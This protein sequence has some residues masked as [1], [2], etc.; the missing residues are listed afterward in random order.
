MNKAILLL[1]ILPILSFSHRNKI[2]I[3]EGFYC[4]HDYLIYKD[5]L[6]IEDYEIRS[7]MILLYI[8]GDTLANWGDVTFSAGG[9]KTITAKDSLMTEDSRIRIFQVDNG[10]VGLTIDGIKK[11]FYYDKIPKDC[12][13]DISEIIFNPNDDRLCFSKII[14]SRIRNTIFSGSYLFKGTQPVLFEGDG[15]VKGLSYFKNYKLHFRGGTDFPYPGHNL[16]ETDNG[17]WAYKIDGDKY[18]FTRYND[19]RNNDDEMY[20]LSKMKFELKRER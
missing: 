8:H 13:Q 10:K 4:L 7:D 6:T 1:I 3:E 14:C 15:Q 9:Y 18:I 20:G 12:N 16:I 2:K 11:I 19:E 17:V 5:K